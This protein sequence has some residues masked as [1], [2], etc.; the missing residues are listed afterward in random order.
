MNSYIFI[1]ERLGFRGWKE[2]DID[3]LFSINSNDKVMQYFPSKPNLKE[4]KAFIIRMQKMYAINKYCYF[5]VEIL[6]TKEFIGFIGLCEQTYEIHF[7]PS[8][9]IGW[10]MHPSFWGKGYATEGAKACLKYGFNQLN[11][12]K[13][14]AIAPEINTPSIKVME[15]IGMQKVEEFKH[16]LL[17]DNPE[18]QTCV[19]YQ[20][21][22]F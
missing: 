12:D 21:S 17:K 11:L 19:L 6:A 13:I 7:N 10:R 16:P 14:V 8:I 22:L 1:S 18:L 2:T 5:A 15:N 4:T 9:D 3:A 20:K